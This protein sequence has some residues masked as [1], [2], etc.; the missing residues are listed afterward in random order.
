MKANTFKDRGK[1]KWND[2]QG[3]LDRFDQKCATEEDRKRLPGLFRRVCGD[4]SLA[5]SR[6]YGLQ[7]TEKL[8]DLVSRSYSHLHHQTLG[9]WGQFFKGIK[10]TFPQTVRQ[11]WRL[12][13]LVNAFFWLPYIGII[14]ASYYDMRWIESLLGV[15]EMTQLQQGFGDGDGF[16]SFRDNFGS[17]FHMFAFYI[18]NNVGIDFKAF[19]SGILAGVGTLF[20]VFFNALKLG[21]ATGYV[22]QEANGGKFLEWVSGHSCPEF[23]GLLFSGMAGL[24]LGFALINPG[25]RTR[26]TALAHAAKRSLVL[27]YGAAFLTFFAAII[28][29]FWS[30]QPFPIPI[31]HG[32]GIILTA[33]LLGYLL[34]AG[35]KSKTTN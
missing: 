28:E 9:L 8:N 21:A 34:F 25:Q 15:E 24:R 4:L 10:E 32:F 16:S 5:R 6:M 19:A 17:N 31:K 14:I 2:L 13:W 30:P 11:E 27:L 20:F 29:G 35:R 18:R 22:I 1:Q 26:V 23:L 3:I 33:L 7:L 12:L